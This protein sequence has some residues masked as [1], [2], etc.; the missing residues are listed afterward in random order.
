MIKDFHI[1]VNR[2]TTV[3]NE[4]VLDRALTIVK[5]DEWKKL[6]SVL[7]SFR[8]IKIVNDQNSN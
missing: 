3:F 6:R 4:P 2:N 1:F 5:D 8:S 7:S